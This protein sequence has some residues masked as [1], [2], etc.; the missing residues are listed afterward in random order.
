MGQWRPCKRNDCVRRLRQ[1]GFVGLYS[2]AKHQFMVYGNHRLT[3]PSNKEYSVPQLRMIIREVERIVGREIP[4][5]EWES[6]W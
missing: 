4:M 6:L 5:D 1:L 2:G 3:I